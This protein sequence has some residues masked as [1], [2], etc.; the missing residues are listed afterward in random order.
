VPLTN[1]TA[2]EVVEYLLRVAH[3]VGIRDPQAEVSGIVG[4]SRL[5]F[6]GVDAA[7]EERHQLRRLAA[8]AVRLLRPLD[9]IAPDLQRV[10]ARTLESLLP[11][12]SLGGERVVVYGCVHCGE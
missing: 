10:V 2:V 4:V 7:F 8:L 5:V 12:S 9:V 6:E 11:A 1:P 3:A